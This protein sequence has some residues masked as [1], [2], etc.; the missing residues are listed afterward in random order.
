MSYKVTNRRSK[1]VWGRS[2]VNLGSVWAR[3]GVDMGSIWGCSGDVLGV[4]G[5]FW[6]GFGSDLGVPGGKTRR[7]N[8]FK[9]IA[10]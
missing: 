7:K 1:K 8:I 9:H 5:K 4:V 3:S 10:L 2:W 6:R